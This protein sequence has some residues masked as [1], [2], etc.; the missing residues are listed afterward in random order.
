MASLGF[1]AA[2]AGV[3]ACALAVGNAAAGDAKIPVHTGSYRHAATE[4]TTT[5][6]TATLESATLETAGSPFVFTGHG[7][8]KSSVRWYNGQY[9]SN[10]YYYGG[11]NPYPYGHYSPFYYN[12]PYSY[13]YRDYPAY[14]GPRWYEFSPRR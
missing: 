2:A 3:I 1:K 5:A 12:Y 14:S 6:T 10:G 13:Q 9:Y 4:T 7:R 11:S 8:S